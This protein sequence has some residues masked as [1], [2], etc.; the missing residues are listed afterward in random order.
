MIEIFV[1]LIL[2]GIFFVDYRLKKIVNLLRAI[3]EIQNKLKSIEQT[4]DSDRG[5]YGRPGP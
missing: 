1:F 3:L 5:I 4:V 2:V